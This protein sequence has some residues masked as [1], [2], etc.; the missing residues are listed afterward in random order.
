MDPVR[1]WG[2]EGG[3]RQNTETPRE[4]SYEKT[5]VKWEPTGPVWR[6]DAT[7]GWPLKPR[8]SSCS[9]KA[10]LCIWI[11]PVWIV[12]DRRTLSIKSILTFDKKEK[13]TLLA[14]A[15][16]TCA[17]LRLGTFVWTQERMGIRCGLAHSERNF[18]FY[19]TGYLKL[20]CFPQTIKWK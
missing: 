18:K 4:R 20:P 13:K 19:T 5:L 3:N 2:G 6:W 10:G 7:A 11:I 16:F 8:I 17:Q 15:R 12:Q 1:K 14:S 9:G